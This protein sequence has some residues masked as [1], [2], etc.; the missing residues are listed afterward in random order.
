MKGVSPLTRYGLCVIA[1]AALLVAITLRSTVSSDI[2]YAILFADTLVAIVYGVV[3]YKPDSRW[4]FVS[5]A[6]GILFFAIAGI[7]RAI[8]NTQILAPLTPQVLFINALTIL[9]YMVLFVG[10]SRFVVARQFGLLGRN[11]D[12]YLDSLMVALSVLAVIWL[13]I[14]NPSIHENTTSLWQKLFLAI[15]PALSLVIVALFVRIAFVGNQYQGLAYWSLLASMSFIFI[16][17]VTYLIQ[18]VHPLHLSHGVTYS[19]YGLSAAFATFGATHPSMRLLVQPSSTAPKRYK[20]SQMLLIVATL[21]IPLALAWGMSDKSTGDH[22]AL[23]I[24]DFAIIALLATR[25]WRAMIFAKNSEQSLTYVANHDE[26][27]GLPNRRFLFSTL[28]ERM[29]K[30][31]RNSELVVALVDLDQFK[32][33][34]DSYGHSY[35]DAL[36]RQIAQRI[37]EAFGQQCVVSRTGGDEFVV[38]WER[39]EH[40]AREWANRLGQLVKQSV[41]INGIEIYVT[42]SIGVACTP[43]GSTA[44]PET[45]MQNADTAMYIAKNGGRD[46]VVFYNESMHIAST[47]RLILKNDLR[48]AIERNELYLVYQPIVSIENKTVVGAEALIRWKHHSFGLLSPVDFIPLAEESGLIRELGAWVIENTAAQRA[49]WRDQ[50]IVP[51]YFYVSINLSAL[52]LMD[53][54]VIDT[55]ATSLTASDLE[56]SMVVVEVTESMVMSNIDRARTILTD[57]KDLGVKI[58]VDDFGMAYSSLAY[59]R[60]FPLD[61]LKIDKS[62]IE[63]LSD[64]NI[65]TRKSLVAA[66]L[67]LAKALGLK[68]IAEGVE[69]Q[70]QINRLRDLSCD[71]VQGFYFSKPVQAQAFARAIATIDK[72]LSRI[73]PPDNQSERGEASQ[74]AQWFFD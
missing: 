54:S 49:K 33:V 24:I 18:Q 11:F 58:V 37:R 42:G 5:I 23:S 13:F 69:T 44:H 22:L 72:R 27:T 67:A 1:L 41:I 31:H 9:G 59:L 57:I 29:A 66:I 8:T 63:G 34:N 17:D 65:E 71:L 70:E 46:S 39:Q 2:A 15:Y 74:L 61:A 35:G 68:A 30:L 19:S 62:F 45:L 20:N 56:G 16:G 55:L 21:F 64:K 36:I 60:S 14:I 43:A 40:E 7:L 12:I 50:G 47:N 73:M 38:V 6:V 32:L 26:L 51:E 10:V 53:N 48:H 52:Q 25:L 28:E 3:I 4:P